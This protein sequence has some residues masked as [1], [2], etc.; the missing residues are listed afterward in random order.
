MLQQY[1]SLQQTPVEQSSV[2]HTLYIV[3]SVACIGLIFAGANFAIGRER[4][5]HTDLHAA[6]QQINRESFRSELPDVRVEWADLRNEYSVTTPYSDG[7]FPFVIQINRSSVTSDAQLRH[8][9]THEMCHVATYDA[10]EA[11]GQDANG[12]LFQSCLATLGNPR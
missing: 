12:P 10:A 11:A 4:T 3:I 1:D 9:L 7:A 6:Y 5:R 8:T 2:R